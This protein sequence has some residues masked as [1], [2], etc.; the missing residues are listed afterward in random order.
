MA[1][2]A[3]TTLELEHRGAALWVTLNRPE[4]LNAFTVAS[5]SVATAFTTAATAGVTGAVVA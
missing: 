4:A 3:Y 1:A 2:D 5:A